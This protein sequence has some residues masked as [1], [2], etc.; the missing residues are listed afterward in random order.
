MSKP[1]SGN[2]VLLPFLFNFFALNGPLFL[3][4]YKWNGFEALIDDYSLTGK[5]RLPLRA[6]TLQVAGGFYDIPIK[7]VLMEDMEKFSNA[8]LL[9]N[10]VLATPTMSYNNWAVHVIVGWADMLPFN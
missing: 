3:Q 1:K 10:N 2:K 9:K 7:L 6:S 4:S 8:N 5:V